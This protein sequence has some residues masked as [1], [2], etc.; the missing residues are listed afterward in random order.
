MELIDDFSLLMEYLSRLFAVKK[1]REVTVH[2]YKVSFLGYWDISTDIFYQEFPDKDLLDRVKLL[3]LGVHNLF[4]GKNFLLNL[5][6]DH[7]ESTDGET[8]DI[9]KFIEVLDS[10]TF[11]YF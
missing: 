3:K 6:W 11:R 1:M 5:S 7:A 8:P 4:S 10:S 9:A 2:Q